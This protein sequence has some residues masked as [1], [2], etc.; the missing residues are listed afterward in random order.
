M[1][2]LSRAAP[3][4]VA[5]GRAACRRRPVQPR[6][7]RRGRR[8]RARRRRRRA[9]AAVGGDVVCRAC[10]GRAAAA[11]PRNVPARQPLPA[12]A[13][14][15]GLPRPAHV[16]QPVLLERAL[17]SHGALVGTAPAHERAAC[18]VGLWP[19]QATARRGCAAVVL[20]VATG[21]RGCVPARADG[22][23]ARAGHRTGR[24][25]AA[26]PARPSGL[27]AG[28]DRIAAHPVGDRRTTR[29]AAAAGVPH[30]VCAAGGTRARAGR[31]AACADAGAHRGAVCA[32]VPR[33]VRTARRGGRARARGPPTV[34]G[35]AAERRCGLLPHARRRGRQ[36]AG[37]GHRATDPCHAPL[38]HRRCCCCCR[39]WAQARRLVVGAAGRAV[40]VQRRR[41]RRGGGSGG[42]G[43][44]C[45]RPFAGAVALA[46]TTG[47][48]LC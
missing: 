10:A 40:C 16:L 36:R 15:N 39:G 32:G 22:A 3:G 14:R 2:R 44:G 29:R 37:A 45:A 8:G 27:A 30:G 34:A 25:G 28:A 5:A 13:A 4:Q 6:R 11:Q 12:A 24:R 42:A 23:L 17:V 46:R 38:P 9:P 41:R 48:G 43:Y 1:G 18:A 21:R 19:I 20:R 33:A 47:C 26:A 7:G 31:V 35:R